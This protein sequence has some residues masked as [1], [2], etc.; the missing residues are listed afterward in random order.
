MTRLVAIILLLAGCPSSALPTSTILSIESRYRVGPM[1]QV[2]PKD[3]VE[4]MRVFVNRA[5]PLVFAAHVAAGLVKDAAAVERKLTGTRVCLI[6][7]PD[8]CSGIQHDCTGPDKICARRRGCAMAWGR[9]A[10]VS[11][12]WPPICRPDYSSE[13]HCVSPGASQSTDWHSDGIH[14]LSELVAQTAG[15]DAHGEPSLKAQALATKA[16]EGR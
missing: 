4:E 13:P 11:R 2:C 7:Q 3:N 15:F 9:Y 16:Y 10:W 14:E 5:W 1:V 8:L 12:N 6:D